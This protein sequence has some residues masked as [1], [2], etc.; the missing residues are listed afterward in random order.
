MSILQAEEWGSLSNLPDE[1]CAVPCSLDEAPSAHLRAIEKEDHGIA[2]GMLDGV[3]ESI[4][5]QPH[6]NDLKMDDLD[7]REF[8][9]CDFLIYP[10]L[11]IGFITLLGG[12]GGAFKSLLSLFMLLC[13]VVGKSFAGLKTKQGKALYYSME[14]DTSFI[15]SRLQRMVRH[16]ALT[17]AKLSGNLVVRDM[18]A[19]NPPY[20]AVYDGLGDGGRCKWTA[21][22][23]RLLADIASGNF[24]VV[25]IDNASEAFAG[26]ENSRV[27][28]S[29]FYSKLKVAAAKGE[30]A[31][32]L[33]AHVNRDSA[34]GGKARENYSGSTQWHNG[35]RSR[36]YLTK[37]D[38]TGL[39]EL[40]QEKCN[41]AEKLDKVIDGQFTGDEFVL[42]IRT[43]S[44]EKETRNEQHM[45]AARVLLPLIM[46][47]EE[48]GRPLEQG[49]NGFYAGIRE[50][51]EIPKSFLK[52]QAAKDNARA[53]SH[54]LR[55]H[56]LVNIK[57]GYDEGGTNKKARYYLTDAGK[58]AALRVTK[59]GEMLVAEETPF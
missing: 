57:E 36:L 52:T 5:Y 43:A 3:M 45:A 47:L 53:G 24:D 54:L 8:P 26:N 56:G 15:G 58:A 35:A 42:T 33:L 12:H 1:D 16:M 39:M 34:K 30:C 11:P 59:G 41:P 44:V 27:E 17:G 28:V 51:R 29:A 32:L 18:T 7:S 38:E 13:I 37:D 55:D 22:G 4:G 19:A 50:D 48:K 49:R 9:P 46:R 31:V 40:T 23:E 14:D 2:A 25:V 20:L 10:L 6:P 21:D